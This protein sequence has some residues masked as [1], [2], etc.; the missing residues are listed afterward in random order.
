MDQ[1]QFQDLVMC[2][3]PKIKVGFPLHQK[4]RPKI[5]SDRIN[6]K[7]EI[8]EYVAVVGYSKYDTN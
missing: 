1:L 2:V 7:N 5:S 3:E 4:T 6:T 8:V